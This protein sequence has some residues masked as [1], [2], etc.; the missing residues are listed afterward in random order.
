MSSELF[1]VIFSGK[2]K[3]GVSIDEVQK[4]LVTTFKMPPEKVRKIFTGRPITIKANIELPI[5]Q[6]YQRAFEGAGAI[7]EI[8][9]VQKESEALTQ[10][11][12]VTTQ[13][14]TDKPTVTKPL[15]AKLQVSKTASFKPNLSGFWR[16]V[17]AFFIDS[18]LLGILGAVLGY[19]FFDQFAK[20]G[21]SGRL[22]GCVIAIL[23]FGL[24]NSSI[25][26]GQTVGKRLMKI[27]VVNEADGNLISLP[28]SAWRY[29]VLCL[30]L[31]CNG[32]V[33]PFDNHLLMFLLTLI[34][35]GMGGMLF[36]LYIFNRRTRQS[37]HDL[38]AK[39]LVVQNIEGGRPYQPGVWKGHY[40]VAISLVALIVGGGLF[41]VSALTKT[42]T[43]PEM[44]TLQQELMAKPD[45]QAASVVSGTTYNSEGQTT[46]T[47]VTVV[48]SDKQMMSEEV[49]GDIVSS[50]FSF[51][52]SSK[53]KN[54]LK[55]TITYGYDIG[56]STGWK[57]SNFVYTP[58]QWA[59]KLK[60]S[61]T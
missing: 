28:K 33:L 2:I 61:S 12:T 15:P 9:P 7:C 59:T 30:P 56:I 50:T 38:A 54:L 32:L 48:V 46:H 26:Q 34:V 41:G 49:A 14:T 13:N 4:H 60:L 52:P 16:R 40:V 31:L 43:F 42:G 55:V 1:N 45:I 58:E 18:I 3:D 35:F 23:Y 21:Q 51:C 27:K 11:P 47:A 10:T 8:I 25:G 17:L 44:L 29:L 22:I 57:N 5:A 36:Y 39:T 20:L 6:K 24:L 19:F 37:I 53:S